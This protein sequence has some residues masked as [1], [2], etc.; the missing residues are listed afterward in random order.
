MSWTDAAGY[1]V[2]ALALAWMSFVAP[3]PSW[4][5]RWISEPVEGQEGGPREW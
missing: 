3:L 1:A 5:A 2:A 4:Y